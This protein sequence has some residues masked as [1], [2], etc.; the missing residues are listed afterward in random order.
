MVDGK[1]II[2]YQDGVAKEKIV[3]IWEKLR[4]RTG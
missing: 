3:S 4:V 1:T 2:E